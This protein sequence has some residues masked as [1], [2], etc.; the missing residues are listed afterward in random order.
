M[1]L[2]QPYSFPNTPGPNTRKST[3]HDIHRTKPSIKDLIAEIS[4]GQSN[5]RG[6]DDLLSRYIKESILKKQPGLDV[7]TGKVFDPRPIYDQEIKHIKVYGILTRHVYFSIFSLDPHLNNGQIQEMLTTIG[8][9][10]WGYTTIDDGT[11]HGY[12][13]AYY[14]YE[15]V[16]GVGDDNAHTY[17]SIMWPRHT[18]IPLLNRLRMLAREG[19]EHLPF[20]LALVGAIAAAEQA[21]AQGNATK[22]KDKV[23]GVPTAFSIL[24]DD[25]YFGGTKEANLADIQKTAQYMAASV[26]NPKYNRLNPKELDPCGLAFFLQE[27]SRLLWT[28]QALKAAGL[29]FDSFRN[30]SNRF[31]SFESLADCWLSLVSFDQIEFFAAGMNIQYFNEGD[32]AP[33][34]LW[35]QAIEFEFWQIPPEA[36]R[37]LQRWQRLIKSNQI[38]FAKG[39]DPAYGDALAE[40]LLTEAQ[41]K[42]IYVPSGAFR[43]TLPAGMPVIG[44]EELCIWSDGTGLW[45]LPRPDG[46]IF[47]WRPQLTNSLLRCGFEA[48]EFSA[49]NLIL[50]ALWHDL[51]TEGSKVIVRTGDEQPATDIHHVECKSRK[52]HSHSRP[53]THV[54]RLP[55]QRVIHL[56][57]VHTWGTPDEIE[58]IKRQA[59]QVRGHRRRLLPGHQRS[60]YALENARRFNFIMPDGYTFVKPYQTGLSDPDAPATKETPIL[61]RG[62]AS[63]MLMSKDYSKRSAES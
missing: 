8:Q 9:M 34:G 56:D 48:T 47:Y 25:Y 38:L 10:Y 1:T 18:K 58:K 5:A 54:L 36:L 27:V 46:I 19:G 22:G 15:C 16:D 13:G 4:S 39:Y 28:P 33:L 45:I 3:P 14:P 55:S 40:K 61:A 60:L 44:V 53:D 31:E 21:F 20:W 32:G 35:E 17:F 11:W 29:L 2:P 43:T 52:R 6:Q 26:T 12:F 59:H 57:G 42:N 49:W 41:Q 62:L 24:I 63:L 51:V 23:T 30:D 7:N 37:Y 50:S